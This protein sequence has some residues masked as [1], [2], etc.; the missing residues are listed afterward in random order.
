MA[1]RPGLSE[2]WHLLARCYQRQGRFD[3]AQRAFL[4]AHRR[5]VF[6]RYEDVVRRVAAE[7][8]TTLVDLSDE[9]L[10]ARP[11]PLYVDDMHPNEQGHQL[12]AEALSRALLSALRG[13]LASDVRRTWRVAPEAGER[14]QRFRARTQA[15]SSCWENHRG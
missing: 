13:R 8:G 1:A 4:E 15:R 2:A 10:A 9:F 7:T 3:A 5:S 14:P 12:I 6:R 11:E